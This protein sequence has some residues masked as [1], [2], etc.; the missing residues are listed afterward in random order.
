MLDGLIGGLRCRGSARRR[1]RRHL[2]RRKCARAICRATDDIA[3]PAMA[4]PFLSFC[5]SARFASRRPPSP[6][7]GPLASSGSAISGPTARAAD[8]AASDPKSV[9][10]STRRLGILPSR[11][12]RSGRLIWS[13]CA[14]PSPKPIG[15]RRPSPAISASWSCS[16]AKAGGAGALGAA[17]SISSVSASTTG[18]RRCGSAWRAG[19]GRQTADASALRQDRDHRARLRHRDDDARRD[20]C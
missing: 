16:S 5:R 11:S 13:R 18:S 15:R 12:N 10:G 6:L 17:G 20:R 8:L 14:A 3:P 1:D 9:A 4:E 19:P 7:C 2:G